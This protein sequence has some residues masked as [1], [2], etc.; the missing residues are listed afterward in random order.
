MN[1]KVNAFNTFFSNQ[2]ISVLLFGITVII[3]LS[4]IQDSETKGST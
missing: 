1:A 2:V 4:L 3:I